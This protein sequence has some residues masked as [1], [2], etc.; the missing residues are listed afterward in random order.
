MANI[1]LTDALITDAS[2]FAGL[3][4]NDNSSI[5]A[6]SVSSNVQ[7]TI[8]AN[9]ITFTDTN[10]NSVL[11]TYTNGDLGGGTFANVRQYDGNDNDSD[12]SGFSGSGQVDL[13]GGSGDDTLTDSGTNGGRLFGGD[14]DDVLQGGSGNNFDVQGGAGNDI[15]LSGGGN[16]QLFGGAGDDV[17]V[18]ESGTG[19]LQGGNGNDT[20]IQEDGTYNIV[21]GNG[22]DTIIIN[23]GTSNNIAANGGDDTVILNVATTAFVNG[24]GGTNTL[25]LPD[26]ATFAPFNVGGNNGRITFADGSSTGY[27]GFLADDISVACFA[28]GTLIETSNGPAAIECLAVGDLVQ[29]LDDGLQE[30]QWIGQCTVPADGAFAPI[31]IAK[32]RMGNHADLFVSPQHRILLSGANCDLHFGAPEVLCAAKHLCDGVHVYRA[33]RPTITY[34]HLMFGKHQ[35]INANGVLAESF[36]VGDYHSGADEETYNELISL[37]P[38]LSQNDHPARYPSRPFLKPFE[39]QILKSSHENTTII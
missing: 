36:F 31:C 2:F 11:A 21:A 22:A 4:I 6:S 35:I 14:G 27:Q 30:L 33:T 38:E 3:N 7:I 17:L 9:A 1:T 39:A 25:V 24:G 26:G 5:N 37:F 15:L 10:T 20:I 28:S 32:G 12:V 23:G 19:N 8:T 18:G 16:N 13:E 29:T 34:F